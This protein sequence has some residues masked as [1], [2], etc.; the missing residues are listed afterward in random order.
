[1]PQQPTCRH[2]GHAWTPPQNVMAANAYC[3]HCSSSRQELAKQAFGLR[4]V[5]AADDDRGGY[6]IRRDRRSP[7]VGSLPEGNPMSDNT[8][9]M[10]LRFKALTPD[11]MI[12]IAE[13]VLDGW[14]YLAETYDEVAKAIA[15]SLVC[16]S[17]VTE[18]VR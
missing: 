17:T 12:A 15:D 11:E 9:T 1:M 2:R 8:C 7:S 16:M 3:E 13:Y 6:T 18:S 10:T 4:R 5:T 14:A